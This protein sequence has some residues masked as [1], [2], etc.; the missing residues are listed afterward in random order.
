[1][2]DGRRPSLA[3]LGRQGNATF[4]MGAG[5]S[6]HVTSPPQ[7]EGSAEGSPYASR[8]GSTIAA[9]KSFSSFGQSSRGSDTP[10]SVELVDGVHP[11]LLAQAL[12]AA[13]GSIH[14][15]PSISSRSNSFSRQA[16]A[17]IAVLP[18]ATT[19]A[20][21]RSRRSGSIS[22]NLPM[23]IPENGGDTARGG[24]DDGPTVT[25]YYTIRILTYNVAGKKP[26]EYPLKDILF[27]DLDPRYAA[28][29]DR[30][31]FRQVAQDG[32]D[33]VCIGCQEI[34]PLKVSTVVGSSDQSNQGNM[35]EYYV[36]LAMSEMVVNGDRYVK[37]GSRQM[38]GLLLAV[39]TKEKCATEFSEVQTAAVPTGFGGK[40][41]NKGAV[42][43]RF[44]WNYSTFCF[45]TAHLT[46]H[47]KNNHIRN[48]EYGDI[49]SRIQ[50]PDAPD[51]L[52]H[53]FVF[54]FG[55]L[56]YRVM[57]DT[58][59]VARQALAG[60]IGPLLEADQLSQARASGAAFQHFKEAPILFPPTFKYEPGT[61]NFCPESKKRTPSWTDRVLFLGPLVDP[62]WYGSLPQFIGSDHRP[63]SA[64]VR[65]VLRKSAAILKAQ[66]GAGGGG[67]GFGAR[68]AAMALGG[69]SFSTTTS[70]L[71]GDGGG[72]LNSGKPADD[73][74]ASY[75]SSGF[76][77][78]EGF[79]DSYAA[80]REEASCWSP[81]FAFLPSCCKPN[82]APA[83]QYSAPLNAGYPA[84][85][86]GW[87][88][89][90]P[91]AAS[92]PPRTP[93]LGPTPSP[94]FGQPGASP[95]RPAS[96]QTAPG[97]MGG[98]QAPL[99]PPRSFTGSSSLAPPP[100]SFGALAPPDAGEGSRHG[101]P[102]RPSLQFP[103]NP[104]RPPSM[105]RLRSGSFRL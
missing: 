18:V 79:R 61:N 9:P 75:G 3:A 59:A 95:Q 57:G 1:M 46:P 80:E 62:L 44:R 47:D 36:D 53:N 17:P 48:K 30:G 45:L 64:V 86:S 94:S 84:P 14:R 90:V 65:V 31:A 73:Y 93:E 42:C 25:Q 50:F 54:F 63:V 68:A 96:F 60:D 39:Y 40:M 33:V 27:S 76:S 23:S 55:D 99:L 11:A 81:F 69:D 78:S 6:L 104:Q 26:S 72:A 105:S 38:V 34:I 19:E 101:S 7:G 2:A 4:S 28:G 21:P 32:P 16:A 12:N 49:L 100:Q 35:W 97:A 24:P 37:V 91:P 87:T 102:S 71:G 43:L 58:G 8:R 52:A 10:P 13:G 89:P 41:K 70:S 67:G 66:A 103:E 5:P 74:G 82:E 98:L 15:R 29:P 77:S 20:K 85:P 83:K 88:S 56:N 22:I 92:S 51:V